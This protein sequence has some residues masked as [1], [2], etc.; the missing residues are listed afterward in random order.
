MSHLPAGA[1][2]KSNRLVSLDESTTSTL[3]PLISRPSRR[4]KTPVPSV[5]PAPK[6]VTE[7]VV[8]VGALFG[9]DADDAQPRLR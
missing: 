1:L 2:V 6:T 5:N 7:P 9:D 4:N 3:V 8:F